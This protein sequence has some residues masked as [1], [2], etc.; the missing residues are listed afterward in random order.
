MQVK[1]E[2]ASFHMLA[3][4]PQE[5]LTKE[6]GATAR[7]VSY[8][9]VSGPPETVFIVVE[10]P[11]EMLKQLDMSNDFILLLRVSKEGEE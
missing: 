2:S 10:A 3:E 4:E 5:S 1:N 8:L 9:F 7:P 11:R 6:H